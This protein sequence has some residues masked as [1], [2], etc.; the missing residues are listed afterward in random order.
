ML[1]RLGLSSGRQEPGDELP[2]MRGVTFEFAIRPDATGPSRGTL[3]R[4]TPEP[5]SSFTTPRLPRPAANES[6]A[7]GNGLESDHPA[8]LESL[9]SRFLTQASDYGFGPEEIERIVRRIAE[10]GD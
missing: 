8:Q 1:I 9:C 3:M 4:P 2:R 10:N 5:G 6:A 7:G